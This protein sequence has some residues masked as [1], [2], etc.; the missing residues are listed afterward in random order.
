MKAKFRVAVDT[1]GT[2]T[3]LCLVD[4]S[5]GKLV[6]AKVASTPSDPAEGVINGVCKLMSVASVEAGEISFFLHGTTVATNALLEG[7]GAPTSLITTEGFEDVLLIGRQNRP[8]L[9]DF[10][11][12]RPR[13]I[14]PRSLCYGVPERIL[15]TGEILRPLDESRVR[16]IVG[17]IGRKGVKSIAVCLLHSY[18]NPDHEQRIK[19]ILQEVYPEAFATISSDILP[20]YREYERMSTVCINAYV[21]PKVNF[22]VKHLESK[23]RLMGVASDLYIMQSN[24]GVIT[25][26]M[27]RE[28]SATDRA[29]RPGRRSADRRLP[30]QKP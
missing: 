28:S 8:R 20:E 7:K 4:D 27:A 14:V 5:T 22:Y 2:F 21:M 19:A 13:P 1:G 26:Q 6:V 15:Y 10:W 24:G 18:A 12:H 23:L 9:Y 16:E 3:D 17:D 11:A 30:V 25:A 29:F